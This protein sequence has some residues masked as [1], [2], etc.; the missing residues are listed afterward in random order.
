VTLSLTSSLLHNVMDAA[1]AI[2]YTVVKLEAALDADQAWIDE[3]EANR[4]PGEERPAAMVGPNRDPINYEL[5]NLLS[6]L[7]ILRERMKTHQS[8]HDIGLLPALA[9][10]ETWTNSI[11]QRYS[12]LHARALDDVVLAN[13]AV[14]ITPV[15]PAFGATRLDQGRAVHPIPDTPKRGDP[16][17]LGSDLSYDLMRDARSFGRDVLEAVG[18]FMDGLL[19]AFEDG[20]KE[21]ARRREAASSPLN[22]F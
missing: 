8:G 5:A 3:R 14:H 6:W 2:E 12:A 15:P 20:N 11:R 18:E 17:Y 9:P 19:S 13:V 4:D 22:E 10:D 1:G 7:K 16:V 21:I